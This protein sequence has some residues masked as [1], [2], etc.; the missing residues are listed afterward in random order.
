MQKYTL[1][2][3]LKLNLE[4]SDTNMANAEEN[5]EALPSENPKGREIRLIDPPMSEEFKIS[6]QNYNWDVQLFIENVSHYDTH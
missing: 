6:N 2:S 5:K 1:K 3:Y 4:R